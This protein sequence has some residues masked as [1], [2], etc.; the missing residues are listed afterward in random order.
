MRGLKVKPEFAFVLSRTSGGARDLVGMALRCAA[1][2]WLRARCSSPW[3]FGV[4]D[5]PFRALD[6]YNRRVLAAHIQRMVS[7]TFDQAL[8]VAHD[9]GILDSM[10]HRIVITSEGKWSRVEVSA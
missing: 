9:A 6:R 2:K 1:F 5:E 4:M 8:L 3:S 10:Q 7:G